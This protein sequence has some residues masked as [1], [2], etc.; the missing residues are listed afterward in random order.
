M[1][2]ELGYCT[3]EL[4]WQTR[5]SINWKGAWPEEAIHVKFCRQDVVRRSQEHYASDMKFPEVIAHIKARSNV[6]ITNGTN[7]WEH[8]FMA[9]N[10]IG[11]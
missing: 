7:T 6:L 4:G 5:T 1:A 9:C 3:D 10:V 8:N 11:F 2:T